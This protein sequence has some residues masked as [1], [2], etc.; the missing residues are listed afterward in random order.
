MDG[1]LLL[2]NLFQA[3]YDARKN[4]RKTVSALSFELEYESN[5]LKLYE[6]IREEQYKPGRSICFIN[7][8]P[9]KRE[10]FAANFRDRIVHHLIF[11]YLN[12]IVEPGF[13]KDSYSCRKGKGTHFA[14][15]RMRS[16]M[17]SVTHNY[18]KEAWVLKI[19]LLAYFMLIDRGKL[20]KKIE[21]KLLAFRQPIDF[22]KSLLLYLL[23]EVIFYDPCS[24]CLIKGQASD[25]K[26]L[27]KSKSLFNAPKGKGFPIGNLTSQLFGN[28]YLNEFDH[29]V[30]E[31]L[32]ITQYGRYVDDMVLM[33]EDKEYL[34][35][36]LPII[37]S[38][39]QE[40]LDL[41]LHPK[42][43][44]L[45][46]CSKGFPYLGTYIKPYSVYIGKRTK[47]N[48][49]EKIRYWNQF[50]IDHKGKLNSIE[51]NKFISSIN[52]YLGMMKH[53]NSYRLRK[54]MLLQLKGEFFNYVYISGGYARLVP[55]VKRMKK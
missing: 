30:K 14:I 2:V 47:G 35:Q 15:K 10:I 43:I 55:K 48:F 54:K 22:D 49:Y 1:N 34:K 46:S 20:F 26:G 41:E 19:D 50:L 29:F 53:Y 31:D 36:L 51:I 21:K 12:P 44:Y 5:L 6:E 11:N 16:F 9:V 4:K 32:G 18:Q 39:L 33:H 45:Q 42:K 27:P 37:K 7:Y 28:I 38:Y 23:K 25:W 17:R 40:K 3:Y 8:K 52:S 24:N 13:I